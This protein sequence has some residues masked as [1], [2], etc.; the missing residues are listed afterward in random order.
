VLQHWKALSEQERKEWEDKAAEEQKR[1]LQECIERASSDPSALADSGESEGESEGGDGE[2]ADAGDDVLTLRVPQARVTR[3]LRCNKD[4]GKISRDACF[5][6]GKAT[7]D[8]L[9]QCVA[10]ASR[11]TARSGRKTIMMRDIITSMR[12]AK[13]PDAL[14]IFLDE[15]QPLREPKAVPSK[16]ATASKKRAGA[17]KAATGKAAASAATEAGADG[18]D[19]S[20][21][22]AHS[23]SGAT[24]KAGKAAKVQRT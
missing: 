3:I 4:I 5:L 2:G 17:G 7:E 11:V 24:G 18:D 14:Q 9:E 22:A 21:D 15:F 10:D 12:E 23:D 16:K 6:V 19:A 20:G 8:F 13:N 1:Y